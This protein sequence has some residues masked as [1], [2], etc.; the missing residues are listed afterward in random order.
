MTRR[1]AG[2][3]YIELLLVMIFIGLLARLAVPRYGDMK[4]RAV[5]TAIVADVY[6]I[7]L[8]AFTHYTEKQAWPSESGSGVVPTELVSYLPQNFTFV[9]PDYSYDYEL[10]TLS[11]GT[12]ENPQQEEIMGV[13][14][15]VSDTRLAQAVLQ[16]AKKGYAPIVSGNK[17]TF[18]LTG[19]STS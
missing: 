8:A 18:L 16:V 12:P 14:V 9:H 17:I 5:A 3:S 13:A 19:A 1:R 6:A 2:Y 11:G 4:R 10:W 15:T 7:R